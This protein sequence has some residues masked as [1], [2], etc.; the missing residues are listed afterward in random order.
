MKYSNIKKLAFVAIVFAGLGTQ[1]GCAELLLGTDIHIGETSISFSDSTVPNFEEE[2]VSFYATHNN[3]ILLNIGSYQYEL[4]SLSP[5]DS[6]M[7][8]EFNQITL[9]GL[10]SEKKWNGYVSIFKSDSDPDQYEFMI[11]L[12]SNQDYIKIKGTVD[13][14]FTPKQE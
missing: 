6:K 3:K 7:H 14:S 9:A 12:T 5:G 11:H 8:Y 1:T 2:L 4:G 13:V 10:D